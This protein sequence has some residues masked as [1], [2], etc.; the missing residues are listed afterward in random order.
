MTFMAIFTRF[1]GFVILSVHYSGFRYCEVLLYYVVGPRL[2]LLYLCYVFQCCL[3]VYL[4]R[5]NAA[6]EMVSQFHEALSQAREDLEN[7]K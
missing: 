5:L 6:N 2:Y 4:S 1:W 7:M 3:F